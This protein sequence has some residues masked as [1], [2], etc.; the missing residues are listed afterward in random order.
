MSLVDETDRCSIS[1]R[2]VVEEG[3][4]WKE[5]EVAREMKRISKH[6]RSVK[7]QQANALKGNMGISSTCLA[8]ENHF[9]G[10]TAIDDYKPSQ[11]LRPKVVK[12]QVDPKWESNL[13]LCPDIS[14][15]KNDTPYKQN[16]GCALP[17]VSSDVKMTR[18]PFSCSPVYL[19][20]C[21]REDFSW[22]EMFEAD[23]SALR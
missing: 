21:L 9:S 19:D 15:F 1:G 18:L 20:S 7:E 4:E 12:K 23:T 10:L 22:K 8:E 11:V 6:E 17:K 5:K 13:E 2:K 3:V 14:L 16:K